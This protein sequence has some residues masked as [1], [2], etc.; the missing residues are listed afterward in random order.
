MI[1]TPAPEDT[2]RNRIALWLV[3][4]ATRPLLT[5]RAVAFAYYDG[6]MDA[7]RLLSR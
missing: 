7:E 2:A 1:D 3:R 5:G 6:W 4:Y